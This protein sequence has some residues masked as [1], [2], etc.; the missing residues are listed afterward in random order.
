MSFAHRLLKGE[1]VNCCST[2]NFKVARIQHSLT[3]PGK[4]AKADKYYPPIVLLRLRAKTDSKP[5]GKGGHI[6]INIK[7][8]TLT[9]WLEFTRWAMTRQ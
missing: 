7:E 4:W 2:K 9:P 1:S 8:I 6:L 5:F 3:S